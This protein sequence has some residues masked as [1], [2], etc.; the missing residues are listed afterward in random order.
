MPKESKRILQRL[1]TLTSTHKNMKVV[2]LMR[3]CVC[4]RVCAC[5][6]TV[7]NCVYLCVC[8]CEELWR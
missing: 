1:Q 6:V 2:H 8:L 7:R 3:V 4:V 5:V